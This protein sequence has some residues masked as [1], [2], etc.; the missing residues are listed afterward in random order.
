MSHWAIVSYL[1]ITNELHDHFQGGPSSA[2][3]SPGLT[4]SLCGFS[5][6]MRHQELFLNHTVEVLSAVPAQRS[7]LYK[8]G[9]I[10]FYDGGRALA[11]CS[12][13]SLRTEGQ[14]LISACTPT[15]VERRK[16]LC[17]THRISQFPL[18]LRTHCLFW[19]SL[20]ENAFILL[21]LLRS[22]L[23]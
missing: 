10:R 18:L 15:S 22:P 8:G 6:V 7:L 17:L 11:K 12:A 14:G 20:P 21:S 9:Q 19:E 3:V 2:C 4:N 23:S 16:G 13:L 5:L 1:F